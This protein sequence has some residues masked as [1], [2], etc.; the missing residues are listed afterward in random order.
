MSEASCVGHCMQSGLV[1]LRQ[2]APRP[3]RNL[4][5]RAGAANRICWLQNEFAPAQKAKSSINCPPI[6]RRA[7]YDPAAAVCIQ[8]PDS[9]MGLQQRLCVG[10]EEQ[11][12]L[13]DA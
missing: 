9:N 6:R 5:M 11:G 10:K 3:F 8:T 7:Y 4:N 2:S 12:I 13:S 1:M